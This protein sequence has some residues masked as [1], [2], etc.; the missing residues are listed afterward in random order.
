MYFP[1]FA[2][3]LKLENS[4]EVNWVAFSAVMIR[5][6]VDELLNN[7]FFMYFEDVQWCHYIKKVLNKKIYYSPMPKILHHNAGSD[8]TKNGNVWKYFNVALPNEYKWM[9]LENGW[10][11]TKL[12]YLTKSL[13]YYSLRNRSDAW[14]AYQFLKAVIK[15]IQ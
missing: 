9:L 10:M 3:N 4:Q 1:G 7:N 5:R 12:Y 2:K 14:K 8:T 13:H 6:N 15:G 11:Y